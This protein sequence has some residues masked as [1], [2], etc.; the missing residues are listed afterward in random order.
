ML[1]RFPI[2][3]LGFLLALSGI[4]TGQAAPA[5]PQ[6]RGPASRG[7]AADGARY[8][9]HFGPTQN[10]LWKTPLPA[11][12]SSPCVWGER[13]FLTAHDAAADKLETI[14]LERGSGKILWRRFAPAAKI[15]RVFKVNSPAASTPAADAERV[16][17]YFGSFGLLAYDHDG[18]ELWRRPLSTP[19]TGFGAAASPVLLNG[20][21]LL[22]GQGRSLHL[23]AFDPKTGGTA[24]TTEGSPFPSVY[25]TPTLWD[26]NLIVPGKGGLLAFDP[27]D[28]K[29]RWWVPGL[30]PEANTTATDG[31]GLLYV[32]SHLPGGDPDL[33]MKLPPFADLLQHDKNGDGKI[34]QKEVPGDLVI[35]T[36]GGKDGVGEI[37]LNQ[38]YWLFDKNRDGSID[39]QEWRGMTETPFNNALLAIRPGGEGDISGSH[40]VWQSKRGVPEVPSPLW[41]QGRLYLVRNGGVLTCLG[42][43]TGKELYQSRLGPGGMYYAS[44]VA[45]DG[46]VYVA[47]D[48]GVVVVL[49]AGETFEVLAENDLG[50]AIGATPALVGGVLYVRTARHLF[51]FRE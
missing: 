24:W 35:F 27:K 51:A 40:I 46:K 39:A 2:I 30:S 17:V 18:N 25:P 1:V 12:L 45:G 49:K 20:L 6:F 33:R 11:G 10:L 16:H 21:L 43:K 13:I 15:E 28:G 4:A 41:Y 8:P 42:G 34:G 23:M 37:R 38:M 48:A 9:V 3:A 5:W 29:R 31:D 26:G 50:E 19:P 36:R 7:I 44:P 47:A 14:C 22:N 32:A